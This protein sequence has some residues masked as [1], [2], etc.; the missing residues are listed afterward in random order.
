MQ[1][2]GLYMVVSAPSGAGKTTICKKILKMFPNIKYS[3]SYT[4]RP[5]RSGEVDGRDYHFVSEEDFRERIA[6]GGFAEW[7]ENF[8]YL[9]GTSLD[10]LKEN[11]HRGFDLML[12]VETQG[13]RAIKQH[14]PGGA[15]IFIMPPSMEELKKRL[16]GRGFEDR[17][18]LL[19]RINEARDMIKEYD[20]YDYV[21][22]NDSLKNA[23]DCFRSIY[24]AEKSRRS[25][26]ESRVKRFLDTSS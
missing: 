15:F 12:D 25:R 3:V 4:T 8:G 24:L 14:Y 6:N 7:S 11:L 2:Q 19:R 20:W 18:N 5:A 21:I 10:T 9:Y 13:A 16:I 26:W 17:E 22:F 1:D 23:V